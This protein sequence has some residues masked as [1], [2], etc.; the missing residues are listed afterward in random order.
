[1]LKFSKQI[2]KEIAYSIVECWAHKDQGETILRT[3]F[4]HG[5]CAKITC[6]ILTQEN[7]DALEAC[8]DKTFLILLN[9]L[10][11][12]I[13]EAIDDWLDVYKIIHYEDFIQRESQ[14]KSRSV[15]YGT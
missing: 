10:Y 4:S 13:S 6:A 5:R 12:D 3:F 7:H 15:R 9:A 8:V 2:C 1:M 14:S 11:E